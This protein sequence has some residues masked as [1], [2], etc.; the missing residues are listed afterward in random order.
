MILLRARYK[1]NNASLTADGTRGVSTVA[2]VS[3]EFLRALQL[4]CV[5]WRTR[6]DLPA[7]Y[8]A[9][10]GKPD[11]THSAESPGP[12]PAVSAATSCSDPAKYLQHGEQPASLRRGWACNNDVS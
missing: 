2:S 10:G 11:H 1:Y 8:R 3:N 6:T 9:P 12:P 5:R 7:S 4:V